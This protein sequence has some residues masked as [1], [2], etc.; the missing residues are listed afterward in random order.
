M[1]KPAVDD[2]IR[3]LYD[4]YSLLFASLRI[5]V[6][7]TQTVPFRHQSHFWEELYSFEDSYRSV[8][9]RDGGIHENISDRHAQLAELIADM[10]YEPESESE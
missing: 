6:C 2:L 8:L 5:V 9:A 3:E 10:M 1:E 4:V 7:G